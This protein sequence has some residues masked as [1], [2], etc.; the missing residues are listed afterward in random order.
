M[1][2][3]LFLCKPFQPSFDT[4]INAG[5]RYYHLPGN[6]FFRRYIGL[7]FTRYIQSQ[8]KKFFRV[9]LIAQYRSHFQRAFYW[10]DETAKQYIPV[11]CDIYIAEKTRK[12]FENVYRTCR[13]AATNGSSPFTAPVIMSFQKEDKDDDIAREEGIE[14]AHLLLETARRMH[15]LM[16]E[17]FSTPDRVR[18]YALLMNE[19]AGKGKYS[20]QENDQFACVLELCDVDNESEASDM[21]SDA[22]YVPSHPLTSQSHNTTNLNK[23]KKMTMTME[24]KIL[25]IEATPHVKECDIAQFPIRPTT[26]MYWKKPR[27]S[28]RALLLLRSPRKLLC[29]SAF[30]AGPSFRL[31]FGYIFICSQITTRCVVS[32]LSD[33]I[34]R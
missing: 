15:Q 25:Q 22:D 9:C 10:Y 34:G 7:Y 29:D 11:M 21:M 12:L 24:E 27:I 32:P 17:Q 8:D 26:Q 30:G 20:S 4:V 19:G 33:Y 14:D 23:T 2:A 31:F 6:L 1:D 16:I 18:N 5:I 3:S 28:V 13:L